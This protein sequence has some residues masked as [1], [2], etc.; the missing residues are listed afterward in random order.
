MS[1]AEKKKTLVELYRNFRMDLD[2]LD[3]E[4]LAF[5]KQVVG[6]IEDRQEEEILQR[7]KG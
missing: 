7:L 3:R 1:E 5:M 2:H 6:R 4:R